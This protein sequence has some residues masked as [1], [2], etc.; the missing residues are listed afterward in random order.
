M[1][2]LSKYFLS[3]I[4]CSFGH[5][6]IAVEKPGSSLCKQPTK[7]SNPIWQCCHQSK[8]RTGHSTIALHGF[9]DIVAAKMAAAGFHIFSVRASQALL[10]AG[11]VQISFAPSPPTPSGS[12]SLC[13]CLPPAFRWRTPPRQKRRRQLG[14]LILLTGC[15]MSG[16][17]GHWIMLP[18][19]VSD[20]VNSAVECGE[21][22]QS[23]LL[24]AALPVK[25]RLLPQKTSSDFPP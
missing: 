8:S 12:L 5:S 15:K 22:P 25:F 10:P 11:P 4:S 19:T 20:G 17:M 6:I 14:L 16:W 7:N 9:T 2:E 24:P 23:F 13:V 1:V 18:A 21:S 3:R